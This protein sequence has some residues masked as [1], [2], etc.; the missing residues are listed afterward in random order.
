MAGRKLNIHGLGEKLKK[1]GCAKA[2]NTSGDHIF[3]H[4]MVRPPKAAA[5]CASAARQYVVS[6][7]IFSFCAE[8][9]FS[10]TS[11][12]VCV[13]KASSIASIVFDE[14]EIL[15]ALQGPQR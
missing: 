13:T 12:S 6:A 14:Y 7:C 11:P 10:F 3:N 8:F 5:P 4:H 15:F 9:V 2:G 1:H